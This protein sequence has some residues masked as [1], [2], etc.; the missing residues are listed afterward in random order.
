VHVR[1]D[2]LCRRRGPRECDR[3]QESVAMISP[4]RPARVSRE[5]LTFGHG[6]VAAVPHRA[7]AAIA[8][9]ADEPKP[10][11]LL[12]LDTWDWGWGGLLLFS[13]LVFIR[14]QDQISKV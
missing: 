8:A 9:L 11:R 12:R 14:P 3:R 1:D 2:E 6:S 10:V 5:R 4:P 7:A 13:L